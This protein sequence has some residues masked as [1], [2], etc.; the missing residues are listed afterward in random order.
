MLFIFRL[1]VSEKLFN[2]RI[3]ENK[4][5]KVIPALSNQVIVQSE[6]EKMYAKQL[7][8]LEKKAEKDKKKNDF[9]EMDDY[10]NSRNDFDTN[11]KYSL[12]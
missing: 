5:A 2:R 12:F 6:D 4:A 11:E 1:I 8:K 9:E 3:L 10:Y 7:R